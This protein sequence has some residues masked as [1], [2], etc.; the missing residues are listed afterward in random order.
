MHQSLYAY[1]ASLDES[2]DVP[3]SMPDH[4][5]KLHITMIELFK[6]LFTGRI[7]GNYFSRIT[8]LRYILAAS[9]HQRTNSEGGKLSVIL[10]LQDSEG[11]GQQTA[12]TFSPFS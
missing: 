3:P 2:V 6:A 8:K 1:L 5:T 10:T 12:V 11:R 7:G 4:R 9:T